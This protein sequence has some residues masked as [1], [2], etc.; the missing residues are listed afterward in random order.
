MAAHKQEPPSMVQDGG[1]LVDEVLQ[2]KAPRWQRNRSDS[3][4]EESDD[5]ARASAAGAG[6]PCPLSQVPEN[7]TPSASWV[8]AGRQSS[9]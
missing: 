9:R 4:D 3:D 5:L 8:G 6:L 2:G 7:H 1:H